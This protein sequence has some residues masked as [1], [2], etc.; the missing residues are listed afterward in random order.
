MRLIGLEPTRLTT[1][2]PKS[3][4]FSRAYE[5]EQENGEIEAGNI[6]LLENLFN[7]KYPSVSVAHKRLHEYQGFKQHFFSDIASNE[8]A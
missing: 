4:I 5:Y 3:G 6:P 8:E 1:P 2:D 7:E